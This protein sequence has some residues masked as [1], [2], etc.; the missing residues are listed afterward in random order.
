MAT[1]IW[2]RAEL[3]EGFAAGGPAVIE[4]Y[5]STTL[6]GP[7]D[8]FSVGRLGEIRIDIDAA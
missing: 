2:R 6:V 7:R 5:G 4:E 8:R 3:P 1:T